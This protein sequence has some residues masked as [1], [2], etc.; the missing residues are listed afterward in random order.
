V[1]LY[2]A[3]GTKRNRNAV[4]IGNSDAAVLKVSVRW[5][6]RLSDRRLTFWLQYH[7]DQDVAE[8]QR[9]WAV[10][11]EIA[12]PQEIRLQ[13]KSNS[14]QLSG[15]TWRSVHGVLTARVDDTLLRARLQAWMDLIRA[16]WG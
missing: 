15:R 10:A 4:S 2:V 1:C 14:N 3:E 12:S 16:E 8:L 5:L 7:A 11:L 6:R 13:R 9:H